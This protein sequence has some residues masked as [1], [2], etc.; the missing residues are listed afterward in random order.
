[1][2]IPE[3]VQLVLQA[4]T[5]GK[6]GEI[7]V[8]EM[9]ESVRIQ[10][11]A[12]NLIRLSGLQPETE[13]NLVYTGL[14]PGEKLSEELSLAA[15]DTKPTSHD[16]IRVLDG[17]FRDF[18]RVRNWVDELSALVM[19]KN[20]DGL[21]S[22]LK[23]IVPEYHPSEEVLAQCDVDR[24]DIALSRGMARTYLLTSMKDQP[25]RQARAV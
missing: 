23:A 2:T 1:M 13:I 14:R 5:M 22:K 19:A 20:M 8:L 4:S 9:G 17:G 7:F 21:I 10:D 25:S 3:A 12:Y 15:E 11:L 18:Q 24:H 16:K 6:G